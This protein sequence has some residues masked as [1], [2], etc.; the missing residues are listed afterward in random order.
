MKSRRFNNETDL[1]KFINGELTVTLV[2]NTITQ[3]ATVSDTEINEIS[4]SNLTINDE[5]EITIEGVVFTYII[6]NTGDDLPTIF[7]GLISDYV[8]ANPG[9]APADWTV[10][11]SSVLTVE[12]E[13]NTPLNVTIVITAA[14]YSPLFISPIV[15]RF[16]TTGRDYEQW[17]LF[18]N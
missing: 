14:T 9:S 7:A 16:P 4:F 15:S 13:V 10:T 5:V 12:G 3:A 17:V 1:V 18:Y 11:P 6:L 8:T 2:N